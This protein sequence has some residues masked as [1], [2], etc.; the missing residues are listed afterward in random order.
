MKTFEFKLKR[1]KKGVFAM[2]LVDKPG[3]LVDFIKLAK[4]KE[5]PIYLALNKEQKIVTGPAMIPNFKILREVLDFKEKE[6][7]F[8]LEKY[9]Y[10]FFS[11]STIKILSELFM[12]NE[13]MNNITL[14]HETKSDSLKLIESWIILDPKKD[15]SLALG[16]DLPKGTWMVSYKVL[17]DDLWNRIKLDE[18]NGFSIEAIGFDKIEREIEM[19][20]ELTEKEAAEII[21]NSFLTF[22]PAKTLKDK[23]EFEQIPKAE[24]D[25]VYLIHHFHPPERAE[26]MEE[27]HHCIMFEKKSEKG[28][29]YEQKHIKDGKIYQHVLDIEDLEEAP[30]IVYDHLNNGFKIVKKEIDNIKYAVI[31]GPIKLKDVKWA[32]QDK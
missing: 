22:K 21:V 24:Q 30:E 8:T 14:G 15:K 26:D 28:V 2:S 5:S 11:E 19:Q 12:T 23:F 31:D 7:G 17:N 3:I 9:Y 13:R 29:L 4:Y 6:D 18:F 20:S 1:N 16:F 10:M 32:D 27:L 25:W